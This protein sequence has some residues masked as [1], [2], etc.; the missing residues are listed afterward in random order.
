MTQMSCRSA[1]CAYDVPFTVMSHA[2]DFKQRPGDF[3]VGAIANDAMVKSWTAGRG[4]T[5]LVRCDRDRVGRIAYWLG[6]TAPLGG[7]R[8]STMEAP[9]CG[10]FLPTGQSLE[11]LEALGGT[12]E[13]C[14]NPAFST[15]GPCGAA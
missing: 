11:P 12:T 10:S 4:E 9:S 7:A 15:N 3:A 14:W 5:G 1:V 6:L 8:L 13:T 2:L